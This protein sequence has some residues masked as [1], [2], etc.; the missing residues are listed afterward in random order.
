MGPLVFRRI[1]V[2][3]NP[4][5]VFAPGRPAVA[6]ACGRLAATRRKGERLAVLRK[7]GARP[8][9]VWVAGPPPT[10]S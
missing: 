2:V 4:G 9:K 3:K 5:V 8:A 10:G 1:A 6:T 7:A